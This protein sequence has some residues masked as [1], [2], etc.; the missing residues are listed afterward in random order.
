[1]NNTLIIHE[2]ENK[3]SA[4]LKDEWAYF[5]LSSPASG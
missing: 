3:S 1:M 4:M 2:D 5:E